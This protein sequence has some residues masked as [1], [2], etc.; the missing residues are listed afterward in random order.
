MAEKK[1]SK[2]SK[3]SG[4]K[5]GAARPAGLRMSQLMAATG[6]PKSTLLYYVEQGL[7]PR[8]LKTSPNMAYYDPACV[9]RAALVRS[10][11]GQHRLP[12]NKIRHLLSQHDQGQDIAPLV[13][14]AQEVFGLVQDDKLDIKQLLAAT[15]MEPEHLQQ[16]L[17]AELLLPLE[18]GLY[19]QQDLAMA[20]IYVAGRARGIRTQD[21]A[22]YVRQGK[23]IV[24]EEMCLRARLTKDLPPELDAQ[25]S[26]GLVQAARATRSYVIDRLFQH[27]IAAAKDLKDHTRMCEGDD[28]DGA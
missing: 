1:K 19:D 17:E 12:L 14:L 4:A 21:I 18:P 2:N 27:R 13:A 15:G 9:E 16:L 22:Y 6:L 25:V 24:D 26:L 3:R 20:R 28:E 23:R 7:L 11:Q 8:P 10:L 5:R